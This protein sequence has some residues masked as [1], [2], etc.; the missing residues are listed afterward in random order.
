M[1]PGPSVSGRASFY[2]KYGEIMLTFD[3]RGYL[4]EE[5][6]VIAKEPKHASLFTTGNGYMGVRGS[7]EEFGSSC[8]QGAFIRGL[9]DEMTDVEVPFADNLY[10]KKYYFDEQALKDFEKQ[11]RCINFADILL[12]RFTVG[13]ETFYPWEGKILQWRRYLDVDSAMLVREVLWESP[14]GRKTRFRFERFA[15]YEDTHLY[16]MRCSALPIGHAV[17][18]E[19]VSGIDK[20]VRTNGQRILTEMEQ[21]LNETNGYYRLQ[22]GD[23]YKYEVGI[24]FHSA[25]GGSPTQVASFEENGVIGSRA[26]YGGGEDVCVVKTVWLNTSRDPEGDVELPHA[27]ILS[28]AKR[29]FDSLLSAHVCAWRNYFSCFDARI[30]GEPETDGALR[31]SDYHTAISACIGDSVHGLSAKGLTGERYNQFVWWDAEIYQQPVFRFAFPHAAKLSLEYRCAQLPDARENARKKGLAG[32]RFPFVSSVGGKERIQ[33]YVRHPHMQ[34][35]ITADVAYAMLAYYYVIG[36]EAFL[37][38]KGYELLA[39]VLRYWMSRA[40]R[41]GERFVIRTVTGTDEHHPF[42]DNDAYTNYLVK[43]IFEESLYLMTRE[44]E[45]CPLSERELAD[46]RDFAAQL[47]LPEEENGLIP[48]FDGYFGL[49]R[50]LRVEGGG[51]GKGFQMKESGLYQES[52]V[53]KQPDVMVLYAYTDCPMKHE[54][55][56]ENWDYYENMCETSSSLTCPTHTICSADNGRMFSFRKYFLQTVRV[57]IDDIFDCAFQGIHAGCAA[58]G[59]YALLRGVFGVR[60]D[61]GGLHIDPV[62]MPLWERVRVPFF[63]R[64]RK[65]L[66]ELCGSVCTVSVS[67]DPIE[68]VVNGN[69]CVLRGRKRFGAA[70]GRV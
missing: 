22:A 43:Y 28:Y 37:R 60:A 16:V 3:K 27:R 14:Q 70:Y 11:D 49:S 51:V 45:L 4:S 63:W 20:K 17:P 53:I 6:Y 7:F 21:D 46:A 36:D 9:F 19:V 41:D 30:Y 34:I 57:D 58:G 10:M 54:A 2:K 38:E 61:R 15:S 50:T 66:L 59:Y 25:F 5:S 69:K 40:E 1:V 8:A 56:G 48:Q 65:V 64:G 68:A 67:G 44:G 13:G 24:A 26:V 32:A 18:V 52:Q 62:R 47:Y 39:D 12:V 55:Y 33:S 35:H 31:F 29:S 42:V 23:K